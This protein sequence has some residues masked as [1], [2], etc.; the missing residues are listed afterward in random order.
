MLFEYELRRHRKTLQRDFNTQE[1]T[2]LIDHAIVDLR[3]RSIAGVVIVPLAFIVGGFATDYAADHSTLFYFLGTILALATLCR[4]VTMAGFSQ[5]EIRN[6]HILAPFF[7]WANI[8]L[9]MV[10]GAFTCTSVVFYHD[11]I[12]ISL[13]FILLAGLGG[14]SV[15]SY[16]IWK[17]LSYS[18]LVIILTPSIIAEFY[19]GDRISISIGVAVAFFLVF[20]LF[21]AGV[22]NAEFWDSLINVFRIEKHSVQLAIV[23]HK[24]N[25]E[26]VDHK[27]TAL[28]I[29][30]SKKKLQD[31]YNSAHDGIYIL[32]LSGQVIDINDTILAMFQVNRKEA[33]QFNI[34]KSFESRGNQDVDLRTIWKTVLDGQDQEFTWHTT[35]TENE[36]LSTVQVNLRRSLW[37]DHHVII[38]T[39]RDITMQVEALKITIAANRAKSDFIANMSHELRTPLHGILGYARLGLKRSDT[40][41]REKLGEYFNIIM[42]SGTRLVR[43]VNNVLDFS[44]IDVGK[45]RYNMASHDLLPLIKQ[46]LAELQLS[47]DEKGLQ[48][49]VQCRH[50]QCIAYCDEEKTTQVLLNLLFNAIKFSN[51]NSTIRIHCEDVDELKDSAH[52]KVT[53]ANRGARIPP[54]EFHSIFEE[55]I[56]SSATN[57]G[58][59]GTGLGLAISKQIILDHGGSI[60]AETAENGET[61]FSF[62]LPIHM[63]GIGV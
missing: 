38:A 11:S 56:Q 33:L 46:Q 37:G 7:F 6:R 61:L 13:I 53:V 21:Q 31:I 30:T 5:K 48:F 28:A 3:K 44:K 24:L 63:G 36:G 20:N 41:P 59:G 29:A 51:T 49:N 42:E 12:S 50:Q 43:L 18:Y 10:W 23:N 17:M 26:I 57:T 40:I 15:A 22:W 8:F 35:L 27:N 9:A 32:E 34:K 39:I 47:A 45:V 60:W 2:A 1:I 4:I 54:D 62:T 58:A 52:L 16:C 55:F 19:I 14:G 25:K